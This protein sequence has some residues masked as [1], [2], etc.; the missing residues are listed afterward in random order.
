MNYSNQAEAKRLSPLDW[1]MPRYYVPQIY[2]FPSSDPKLRQSLQDGLSGVVTD[3]PYLLSGVVSQ[4][5]PLGSVALSDPYRTVTDIFTWQDLSDKLDYETLKKD[6]FPLPTFNENQIIVPNTLERPL[7][8]PV[9]VFWTRL[10]LVKG[11]AFLYVGL[12]H[13]VTDITGFGSLI[14]LWASHCRVGSSAAAGFD[15]NW[16]DRS[17]L[18]NL[19]PSAPVGDIRASIPDGLFF[20]DSSVSPIASPGAGSPRNAP[21]YTAGIFY[22]APQALEQ[23]KRVANSQITTLGDIGIPWVSTS[24]VITALLWSAAVWAEHDTSLKATGPSGI[25]HMAFPVNFRS[26]W[27]PPLSN[28][29][30]GA[31]CGRA[32]VIASTEE[33]LCL[34][35]APATRQE[36]SKDDGDILEPDKARL[37][38]KISAAVRSA[39]TSVDGEKMRAAIAFTAC[40]PD[41]SH[42]TQRPI[43]ALMITS[44]ADQGSAS[45]RS[46]P[47]V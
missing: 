26:R 3:V 36:G 43:Q 8:T 23:L 47:A 9:P 6:H 13:S 34:S 39:I 21:E 10:T 19:T 28:D 35:S 41:L 7:H 44:W 40:Q 29:Y 45:N 4:E 20:Q 1:L 16:L 31:A 30:L 14:K 12:H 17:A 5:H 42:I 38:A 27:K 15:H 24:D 33:L 32:S 2:C 11:G 18:S 25:S 22:F 46:S 37:L